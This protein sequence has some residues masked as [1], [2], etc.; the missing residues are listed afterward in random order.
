MF[1]ILIL[2]FH[3]E[4]ITEGMA[5]FSFPKSPFSI[6]LLCQAYLRVMIGVLR[7]RYRWC[8]GTLMGAF[9][10]ETARGPHDIGAILYWGIPVF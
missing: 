4:L 8:G 10:V 7:G 9:E 1:L 5:Y 2:I 3:I 6:F